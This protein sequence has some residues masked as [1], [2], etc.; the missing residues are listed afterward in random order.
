MQIGPSL[1]YL[2]NS[3]WSI[4]GTLYYT[5]DNADITRTQLQQY[6]DNSYVI[7][8]FVDNRKTNGFLPIL[9]I[10]YQPSSIL[11][12]GASIREQMVTGKSRY[13]NEFYADSLRSGN[14]SN[15]DFTEGVTNSLS[16]IDYGYAKVKPKLNGEIP[17]TR[18][19]RVGAAYY[20]TSRFLISSDI[21]YTAG[22]KKTENQI[23]VGTNSSG[24]Q[25]LYSQNPER[26]ELYRRP[27]TNY[28]LGLE[29]YLTDSFSVMGGVYTN[30]SNSRP[31]NWNEE[32][33]ALAF[34]NQLSGQTYLE[35]TTGTTNLRVDVP[36]LTYNPRNEFSNNR[37]FSIG[38]GWSNATTGI[39]FTIVRETGRGSSQIDRNSLP[40]SF[41]MDTASA[42]IVVT[43]KK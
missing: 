39:T 36:G 34:R 1:S 42:Y 18:E 25:Y 37:G 27:T 14:T 7:K 15:V 31:I 30:L 28:A 40:Q 26:M 10:Q 35:N 19:L 8:S 23:E 13:Y 11:S 2:I 16:A 22:Y 32:A 4:G 17:H 9:G 3:K 43:S 38:F 5:I 24:K 20:P 33:I 6:N 21:I 12:F 29:Y 41:I